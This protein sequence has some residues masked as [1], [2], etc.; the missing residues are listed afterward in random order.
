MIA[1]PRLRIISAILIFSA[2]L[3]LVNHL[4]A[5]ET[6]DAYI[7]RGIEYGKKKMY[8]EALGEVNKAIAMNPKSAK[9]YHYRATILAYKGDL[10][11]AIVD[12]DKSIEL[13]PD[14]FVAYFSRGLTYYKKGDLGRAIA[15]WDK[16]IELNPDYIESYYRRGTAYYE[17]ND[18]DKAIAD[19]SRAIE[20]DPAND[21]YYLL[22]ALTYSSKEDYDKS[23]EDVHAIEKLGGKPSPEFTE[24]VQV[25]KKESGREK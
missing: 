2:S 22:R 15:D 8:G 16:S 18:Y 9:A 13:D 20:I 3:I 12:W 11:L 5:A 1:S 24:F 14:R 10:D 17:K 6:E 21:E 23:W 7:Q 25:L 4:T 19:Y